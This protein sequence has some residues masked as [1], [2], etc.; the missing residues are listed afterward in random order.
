MAAFGKLVLIGVLAGISSG[1]FGIGGYAIANFYTVNTATGDIDTYGVLSPGSVA[2]SSANAN[3]F[4]AG[5]IAL[6]YSYGYNAGII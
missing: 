1:F 4:F 3:G 5:G 2:I 6:A